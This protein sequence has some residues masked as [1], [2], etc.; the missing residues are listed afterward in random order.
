MNEDQSGGEGPITGH[1]R[2]GYAN[3]LKNHAEG[4]NRAIE[5]ALRQADEQG[6]IVLEGTYETEIR[7]SVEIKYTNPPWIGDYR[8]AIDP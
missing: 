5:D 8:A 1:H 4:F 3:R 2:V 7:F 6:R